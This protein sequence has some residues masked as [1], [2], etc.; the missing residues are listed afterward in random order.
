LVGGY[1]PQST[2]GQRP[3]ASA[4]IAEWSPPANGIDGPHGE[5]DDESRSGAKPPT[6]EADT[7]DTTERGNS[8]KEGSGKIPDETH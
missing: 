3:S 5:A 2:A 8:T 6:M 7:R 1:G 4:E